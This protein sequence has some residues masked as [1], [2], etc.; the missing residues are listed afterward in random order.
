VFEKTTI[1]ELFIKQHYI[2]NTTQDSNQL[3]IFDL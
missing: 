1:N 3:T 2:N